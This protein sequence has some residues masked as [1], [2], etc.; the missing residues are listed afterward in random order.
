MAKASVLPLALVVVLGCPPATTTTPP[1]DGAKPAPPTE[2]HAWL[3]GEWEL[4][5]HDSG[6][7]EH[8]V[9]RG[10]SREGCGAKG[11]VWTFT[12]PGTWTHEGQQGDFSIGPT[13]SACD[14]PAGAI[15]LAGT[16]GHLIVR[17]ETNDKIEVTSPCL[18]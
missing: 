10:A 11:D 3:W 7:L 8:Y 5:N 15:G 4:C 12:R 9:R 13:Q 1:T 16:P 6:A 2:P 18:D 17:Q 14:H